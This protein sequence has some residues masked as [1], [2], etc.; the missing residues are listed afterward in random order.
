MLSQPSGY[1]NKC[2]DK[3]F[4]RKFASFIKLNLSHFKFLVL[5]DL[6]IKGYTLKLYTDFSSNQSIMMRH[7]VK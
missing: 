2:I 4:R 7:N 6:N 1:N 5:V 3:G